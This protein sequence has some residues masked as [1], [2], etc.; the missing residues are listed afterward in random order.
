MKEIHYKGSIAA[1]GCFDKDGSFVAGIVPI[2]PHIQCDGIIYSLYDNNYIMDKM[3][4]STK[5]EENKNFLIKKFKNSNDVVYHDFQT[6]SDMKAMLV[7]IDGLVDK[8]ILNRDVLTPLMMGLEEKDIKKSVH[9]SNIKE[10][11]MMSEVTDEILDGNAVIFIE[12]SHTFF[13][14]DSKSWEKRAVAEPAS[15]SVIRGPKEGFVESLR[16]NTSLLRRK[17]KNNNLVFEGLKKGKQ[18]KTDIAIAYIDNIVNKD[19]LAE[20]RR[21]INR[22][23]TDSILESGYIEQFIEDSSSSL[24]PTVGNTQKPDVAAAKLLEGRVGIFCDG[25]PHVLT[26]PCLF[27]ENLQTSE[28]YYIRPALA[29]AL[30]IFRLLA[31]IISIMLPALYV[32]LT[33]YHQEMIP[34]VLLISMAGAREGIPLPALAEALIMTV[35]FELLRESGTRLP[36][37]IGSAISI[38]GALVLGEAAVNAGLVSA[39]MVIIIATTAV[40][41]FIIPALTE[42][43]TLFRLIFLLLGGIMGLYGI[44]CGMFIIVV[45][46]VS[47]RSFGIPYASAIAPFSASDI[48]DFLFRIP[49]KLMKTRP[50]SIV[51]RNVNRQGNIWRK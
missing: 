9:V 30:R 3:N 45:Q 5:V 4:I 41:S 36:R 7:Y 31:L 26:V 33:T 42:V 34:T 15:E 24:F 25:T 28:D 21:R 51:R 47:L 16:V 2:C 20:V 11:K 14:L 38:V 50:Q 23:D 10:V 18:T 13:V 37:A 29:T 43:M 17:V 35:L 39:P 49:L 46:A 6:Y 22:I 27:I 19:V 48:K 32:A 40:S 44:T 1:G 12:G 8:E